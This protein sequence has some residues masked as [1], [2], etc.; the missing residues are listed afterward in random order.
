VI[1]AGLFLC[2]NVGVD[3]L[4]QPHFCQLFDGQPLDRITV[5]LTEHDSVG[6]Y[7]AV[8]AATR[9]MRALGARLSVDD[10]G[11]GYSGLAHIL[12]LRPDVI[13]LDRELVSDVDTSPA[14]RAL[15]TALVGF[16]HGIDALVVAEGIER[17]EEADCL[18]SLGADLGQGYLYAR[19]MPP[20]Q[21][22]ALAAPGTPPALARSGPA[23]RTG[24]R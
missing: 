1:P 22:T 17:A 19:P 10:T 7:S 8:I 13:K 6:D 24:S 12:R 5:E 2:V 3:L 11:S 15:A 4:L 20:T 21:L 16:A 23:R 18:R 9:R 14:K